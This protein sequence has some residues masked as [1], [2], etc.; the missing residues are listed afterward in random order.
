MLD[1]LLG[2]S[3]F[4]AIIWA[5]MYIFDYA[6]TLWLA[7]AYQDVLSK[8]TLYE[9]GIEL[10][11]VFEKEIARR[12]VASPKFVAALI[13]Y[14]L[15]LL[16]SP[17]IAE[18]FL[19]FIAGAL[20]LTW[21]FVDSRHV[22]NYIYIWLLRKKPEAIKIQ[23]GPQILSYWM[24]QRLISLDAIIFG[25]FYLILAALTFRMFFFAGMIMCFA[26]ALRH[27]LLA[28]RKIPRTLQDTSEK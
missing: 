14:F 27:W 16:M 26:L 3:L 1:L 4:V 19:E 7:G 21:V 17:F 18:S 22:K 15:V 23:G 8:Y 12:R 11:P 10:N 13:L 20:L 5:V 24:M 6:S 2:N 9:G 25:I 28:N